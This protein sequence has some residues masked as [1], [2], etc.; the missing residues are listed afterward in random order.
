MFDVTNTVTKTYWLGSSLAAAWF[1]LQPAKAV[2]WV[3]GWCEMVPFLRNPPSFLGCRWKW[4]RLA[5]TFLEPPACP[6]GRL[7]RRWRNKEQCRLLPFVWVCG[8][9]CGWFYNT[10]SEFWLLQELVTRLQRDWLHKQ[11]RACGSWWFLGV[12]WKGEVGWSWMA[13]V[14]TWRDTDMSG[15]EAHWTW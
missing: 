12:V 6:F 4:G 1:P 8:Q 14:L 2:V 3:W 15:E 9:L 7:G 10:E 13:A 11:L 5:C